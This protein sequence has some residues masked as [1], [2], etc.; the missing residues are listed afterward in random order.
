MLYRQEQNCL[1]CAEARGCKAFRSR[2]QASQ[3]GMGE[4]DLWR[5]WE[6]RAGND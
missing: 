4:P 1:W 3:R 5:N 6:H 2:P